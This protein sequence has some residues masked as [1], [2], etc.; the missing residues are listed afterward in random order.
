MEQDKIS[1]AIYDEDASYSKR[2]MNYLNAKHGKEIDAVAFSKKEQLIKEISEYGF[3][4]VVTADISDI[5]AVN[6][7]RICEQE[8]EEGYYRYG[9][10]KELAMKLLG[11]VGKE[12]IVSV[13]GKFLACYSVSGSS[14]RT[15]FAW[16]KA[17]ESR[18][19]YIGM[20]EFGTQED[21]QHWM[22]ELLFLIRTRKEDVCEQLKEHLM[23]ENRISYLP[24]A[25]CFLDYR[26]LE[27]EDYQWFFEKLSEEISKPMIFDIGSGSFMDFSFFT[28]FDEIYFLKSKDEYMKKRETM[29]LNLIGQ[30]VPDIHEKIIFLEEE[31]V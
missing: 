27:L 7:I 12:E 5:G 19:I 26:H 6:T 1:V 4:C 11:Y 9:S 25:R 16:K 24:S 18:G 22:E 2:L 20:E 8:G 17:K 3:D 28:L 30:E 23:N 15:E 14:K 29:F 10:A 31:S 13:K 21:R